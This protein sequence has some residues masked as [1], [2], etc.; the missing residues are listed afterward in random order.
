MTKTVKTASIPPTPWRCVFA[1]R[2]LFASK[3][4]EPRINSTGFLKIRKQT[5]NHSLKES[6]PKRSPTQPPLVGFS[7]LAFWTIGKRI[8]FI[9]KTAC[10]RPPARFPMRGSAARHQT[11]CAIDQAHCEVQKA[12]Y[13]VT[14]PAAGDLRRADKRRSLREKRPLRRGL[15]RAECL[16][17][18]ASSESL[19][20]IPPAKGPSRS[21]IVGPSHPCL[22][23]HWHDQGA[24]GVSRLWIKCWP[25][26]TRRSRLHSTRENRRFSKLKNVMDDFFHGQ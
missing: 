19:G 13:R 2:S 9:G 22:P 6:C 12:Q 16:T 10:L 7:R 3:G 8:V 15:R 14:H 26:R 23:S 5:L 24:A 25:D 20:V 21:A 11:L 17:Q 4:S 1:V 18:R